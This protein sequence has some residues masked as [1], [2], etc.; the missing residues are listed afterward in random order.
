L[1]IKIHRGANEIG[2]TCVQLSSGNTTILID[3]GLPLVDDGSLLT[4][5]EGK[6]DAVL[7][8]HPHQDHFG[9]IDLLPQD[10]PVFTAIPGLME[11]PTIST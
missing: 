11:Q 8:S 6:I 2:G 3:V 9:L 1:N 10:V 7:I 5:P 4:L